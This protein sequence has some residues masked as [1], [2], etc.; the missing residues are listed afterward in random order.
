MEM[1][2]RSLS[3]LKAEGYGL[4]KCIFTSPTSRRAA[5]KL[6]FEPCGRVDY[7]DV[8]GKDGKFVFPQ[9]KLTDEHYALAMI[10][11]L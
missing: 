6:G 11:T 2:L 1:Y 7:K 4:I 5:F 9:E 8:V 3:F 10:K